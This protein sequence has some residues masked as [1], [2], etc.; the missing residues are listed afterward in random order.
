[1]DTTKM[2]DGIASAIERV[3]KDARPAATKRMGPGAFASYALDQVEKA[4]NDPPEKAVRRLRELGGA[5]DAAKQAFVDQASETIEVQVFQEETTAAADE[6]E[7]EISPVAAEPALGNS[8]F[9]ENPEDLH[10]RLDRLR[11]DLDALRGGEAR[12]ADEV[13]KGAGDAVWPSD[14]NTQEFRE[15]VRKAEGE[16]AWGPD[17][18]VVRNPEA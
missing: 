4:A 18:A 6:S 2:L 13:R 7:K 9:A 12:P 16:P 1:M 14:M 17:P 11:K 10:K 15:G 3:L 8:T 5:V